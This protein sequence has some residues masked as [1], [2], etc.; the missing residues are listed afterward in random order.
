[1]SHRTD[2]ETRPGAL[3]GL[4]VLDL[5]RILAGPSC[6]QLLGDLGADVVKV[7]RPESGDD[8]R[9]WGPPFV[10][11][12][13][14]VPTDLSAYFL[15][16]NRNKRS[17]AVD[18]ATPAGANVIRALARGADVV[19][20]N[21]K[22]GD[23]ERRG[24]GYRE[25]QQ[26]NPRLIWCSITG[27]GRTGPYADRI[28]YDF[29]V[30]AMGGIMSITGEPEGTPQKV[31]V[32]VAD[33]ICGLYATVGILA[34]LAHR[35]RTGEGQMIDLALL[36][37]QLAWLV[38][39]ATNHLVSGIEPRRLGNRH[40]NIAPY[41]T[42]TAADG[43]LVVAVGNDG[44]FARFCDV[45]GY[46]ELRDDPRFRTNPDRVRHVDALEALVAPRLVVASAARW[47]E[48]LTQAQVPAG[49]VATIPQALAH[50]H[51]V[52]RE[53]VVAMQVE[54]VN[55]PVRLVGNPLKLDRTPVAYTSPPPRLDADRS[56]VLRDWLDIGLIGEAVLARS[57]AFG[58]PAPRA[59]LV[60]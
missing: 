47:I 59:E 39:A 7:E 21:Y 56:E 37:T 33:V 54:G 42:Y 57:G 9:S 11:D 34:A 12:D 31:G 48:A 22:P 45:L 44:Q 23:L 2:A 41:Q 15:C 26:E 40:P 46:P 1:M 58:P 51:A 52:A 49:P 16:A 24:L 28:G 25:I 13:E 60:T 5:S 55:D 35:Q 36:D 17:I 8:T 30:Q 27:F 19:V 18:L 6:T 50:P 14:R 20:E 38:N 10:T 4:R 43:H 3:A 53:M 32:G 29:L